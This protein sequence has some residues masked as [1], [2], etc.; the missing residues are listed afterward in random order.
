MSGHIDTTHEWICFRVSDA[1]IMHGF[2]EAM[3]S[4]A[5]G[6]SPVKYD[7]AR[8]DA[9]EIERSVLGGRDRT[10]EEWEAAALHFHNGGIV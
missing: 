3:K 6:S 10:L 2:P 9:Q 4:I 8:L 7:M 5:E 1:Y